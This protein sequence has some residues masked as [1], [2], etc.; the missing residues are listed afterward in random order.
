MDIKQPGD[1]LIAVTLSE[2]GS[3]K[4]KKHGTFAFTSPTVGVNFHIKLHLFFHIILY[5]LFWREVFPGTP[6]SASPF[7]APGEQ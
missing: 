1:T 2:N 6:A 7:P 4:N 3:F 5:P